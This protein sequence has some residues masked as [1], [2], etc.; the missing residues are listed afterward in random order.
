MPRAAQHSKH[1]TM[2]HCNTLHPT[3]S[4]YAILQ[5]LADAQ[6]K[7]H[8]TA[9][10]LAVAIDEHHT[11]VDQHE[12]VLD[13]KARETKAMRTSMEDEIGALEKELAAKN[14]AADSLQADLEDVQRCCSVLHCVAVCCS[15]LQRSSLCC[16]VLQRCCSVLRCVAVCCRGVVAFF[17]VLQY[18]AEVL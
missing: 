17:I 10:E 4:H 8:T 14:V 9:E 15:V 6:S 2:T 5:Q 18:V 13:A 1:A 3:A 12:K 16:S 7:Q 11:E